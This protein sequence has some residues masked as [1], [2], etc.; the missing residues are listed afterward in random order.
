MPNAIALSGQ[1]DAVL[2]SEEGAQ[3][4]IGR[5]DRDQNRQHDHRAV[6]HDREI[7]G[8]P[9][10]ADIM[11]AHDPGP[12]QHRGGDDAALRRLAD[13]QEEQGNA[14]HQR[15]DQERDDGG[16]HEIDRVRRDRRRQHADEMHGPDADGEEAGRARQQ[17]ATAHARRPADARR[18]AETGVTSQDRD[19][20]RERDEI[21]I[22]SFEHDLLG[23][24]SPRACLLP[25]QVYRRRRK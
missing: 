1:P 16:K 19:H 6:V 2:A 5:G 23:R 7:A 13:A 9:V 18:E 17:Y 11:H 24:P 10:N 12:E 25:A 3:P 4:A 21:R 22:V 20:H 15:A 8:Q 14:D